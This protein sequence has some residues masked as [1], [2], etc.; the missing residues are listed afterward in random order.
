MTEA[1]ESGVRPHFEFSEHPPI[2][3]IPPMARH[4]AGR[5]QQQREVIAGLVVG[6]VWIYS[7]WTAP[8]AA[9]IILLHPSRS[10]LRRPSDLRDTIGATPLQLSQRIDRTRFGPLSLFLDT[11]P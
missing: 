8:P 4:T 6:C 9:A 5:G 11:A 2:S 3:P 1:G 10:C 7:C